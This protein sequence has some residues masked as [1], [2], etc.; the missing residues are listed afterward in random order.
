ML[1]KCTVEAL[2]LVGRRRLPLQMPL[3]VRLPREPR[4]S[5]GPA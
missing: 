1:D 3:A 2:V 4:L 5:W